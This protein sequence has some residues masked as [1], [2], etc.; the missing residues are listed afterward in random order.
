MKKPEITDKEYDAIKAKAMTQKQW[1][2]KFSAPGKTVV[3]YPPYIRELAMYVHSR[4]GAS[5]YVPYVEPPTPK[6]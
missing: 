6:T 5:G 2:G 1:L 4:P 3:S